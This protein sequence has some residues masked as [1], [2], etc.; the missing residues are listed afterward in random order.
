MHWIQ[1]AKDT[2]QLQVPLNM[3]MK[4]LDSIKLRK[5]LDKLGDWLLLKERFTPLN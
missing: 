5:F 4:L 1:L 2:V 3:V